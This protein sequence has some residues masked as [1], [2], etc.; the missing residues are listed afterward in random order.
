MASW[1]YIGAGMYFYLDDRDRAVVPTTENTIEV[2]AGARRSGTRF[3]RC[4]ATT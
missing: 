1:K 4:A 2:V 3:T